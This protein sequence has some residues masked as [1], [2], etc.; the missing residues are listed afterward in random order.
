MLALAVCE[1]C[2]ANEVD[3]VIPVLLNVF[4]SRDS[5]LRLMKSA[6]DREVARTGTYGVLRHDSR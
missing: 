5:L 4:D 1:I 6:I 2:P 3:V